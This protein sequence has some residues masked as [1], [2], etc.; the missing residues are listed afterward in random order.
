MTKTTR[1]LYGDISKIFID[2]GICSTD[3]AKLTELYRRA[4][5]AQ[6]AMLE[7]ITDYVGC[8]IKDEETD[9][10]YQPLIDGIKKKYG[11]KDE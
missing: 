4:N 11:V 7:D 8:W 2:H 5:A 3:F 10:L 6:K 1:E 9:E